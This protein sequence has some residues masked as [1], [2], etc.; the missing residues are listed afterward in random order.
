VGKWKKKRKTKYA[1]CVL[2]N[3][4]VYVILKMSEFDSN[5]D[6]R[7][8]HEAEEGDEFSQMTDSQVSVDGDSPTPKRARPS[9]LPELNNA[10]VVFARGMATVNDEIERLHGDA[11]NSRE[12]QMEGARDS[13][14]SVTSSVRSGASASGASTID[15]N[16]SNASTEIEAFFAPQLPDIDFS[17]VGELFNGLATAFGDAAT[18]V[19]TLPDPVR[20]QIVELSM[21][22]SM[23]GVS[24]YLPNIN[25]TVPGV[26]AL[27]SS[28]SSVSQL[29]RGYGVT[30]S[31]VGIGLITG[32]RSDL[33]ANIIARILSELTITEAGLH[34]VSFAAQESADKA[35]LA[36]ATYKMLKQDYEAA[37]EALIN[38]IQNKLPADEIATLEAAMNAAKKK[39]MDAIG[40]AKSGAGA[41]S[42][43]SAGGPGAGMGYGGKRQSQKKQ[44]Q[45]QKKQQKQKQQK[46]T[47]KQQKKLSKSKRAKK[48]K[49]SKKA[50]KKH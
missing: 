1:K 47:Q 25:M 9:E 3:F 30:A 12:A 5:R 43:K 20:T 28:M 29:L 2:L 33:P 17:N 41:S 21:A 19:S 46:K 22:V 10:L 49:Q 39:V 45:Q 34:N 16:A 15:S 31:I 6:K 37:M 44:Q 11:V 27:L 35:K 4:W 50:N 26:N 7:P 14:E 8:R 38:A 13:D 32:I 24:Q 23:L 36:R 40:T 48:A 42:G 18:K